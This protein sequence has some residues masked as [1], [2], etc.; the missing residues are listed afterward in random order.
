MVSLG[1]V[2][3]Y[4][5]SEPGSAMRPAA[6][7]VAAVKP[8]KQTRQMFLGDPTTVI[9]DADFHKRNIPLLVKTNLNTHGPA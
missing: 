7:L 4:G 2:F 9:N 3:D 5:Q 8:L 1:D 6:S